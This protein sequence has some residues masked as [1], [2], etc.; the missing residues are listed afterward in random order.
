MAVA[1]I[2]LA[3]VL[4]AVLWRSSEHGSSASGSLAVPA[5][6]PASEFE[7][8]ALPA[9]ITAPAVHAARPAR[10]AR[11]TREYRGHVVVLTFLYPTC[12]ATCVLIAQQIRGAL[13]ELATPCR[14]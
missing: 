9:N 10:P 5:T 11:V 8:A 14:C 1:T 13:D 4:V 6:G 12:G 3:V 2:V 7:G